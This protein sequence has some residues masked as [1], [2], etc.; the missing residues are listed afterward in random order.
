LAVLVGVIFLALLECPENYI[1]RIVGLLLESGVGPKDLYLK[2]SDDVLD[3]AVKRNVEC[4]KWDD[5]W[6]EED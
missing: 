5:E 1:P 4:T 6:Y 2:E 3:A